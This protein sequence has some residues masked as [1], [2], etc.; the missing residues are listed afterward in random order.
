MK[1]NWVAE[2]HRNNQIEHK[3]TLDSRPHS[4]PEFEVARIAELLLKATTVSA[5]LTASLSHAHPIC[6]G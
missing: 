6:T 4:I 1:Q 2:S 3:V 5:I